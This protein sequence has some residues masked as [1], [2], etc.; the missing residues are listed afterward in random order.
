[1]STQVRVFGFRKH[2]EATLKLPPAVN[3]HERPTVRLEF[4][5][6]SA[7]ALAASFAGPFLGRLPAGISLTDNAVIIDLRELLSRAGAADWLPHVKAL[8]FESDAGVVWLNVA[9]E[10]AP[11]AEDAPRSMQRVPPTHTSHSAPT[12]GEV[13]PLLA[14]TRLAIE[15]RAH[16]SLMTEII[17]AA[18]ADAGQ[19]ASGPPSTGAAAI[20]PFIA[21]PR[22]RFAP[23]TMVLE[24]EL[25]IDP[26]T[27]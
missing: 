20:A 15:V 8:A 6:R 7:L 21:S 23:E 2:L 11:P 1:V 26:P 13:I 25:R 12:A 16:E 22:I 9:I 17:G 4:L 10:I 24:T 5:E 3:F 18:L 14:G 27:T 19:R